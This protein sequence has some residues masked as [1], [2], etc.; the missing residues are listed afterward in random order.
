MRE[1]FEVRK[2]KREKRVAREEQL[3]SLLRSTRCPNCNDPLMWHAE[4]GQD[5]SEVSTGCKLDQR[6]ALE[7][8]QATKVEPK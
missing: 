8:A 1:S 3:A 6:E 7:L 2:K 5:T 4:P